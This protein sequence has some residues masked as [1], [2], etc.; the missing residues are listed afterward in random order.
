MTGRSRSLPAAGTWCVAIALFGLALD[1]RTTV[2]EAGRTTVNGFGTVSVAVPL[3]GAVALV[4]LALAWMRPDRPVLA[5]WA[6][7]AAVIAAL[8]CAIGGPDDADAVH[9]GGGVW[10]SAF[11]FGAGAV[12]AALAAA[13]D[14]EAVSPG[15]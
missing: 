11:G 3:L 13:T 1:W 10:I 2:T 14:P 9:T 4:L 8:V 7:P 12:L 15:R 6:V 5:G